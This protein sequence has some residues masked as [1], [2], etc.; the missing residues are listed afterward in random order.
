MAIPS[1]N[2]RYQIYGAI[3]LGILGTIGVIRIPIESYGDVQYVLN[4]DTSTGSV[5]RAYTVS[6]GRFGPYY[7]LSVSYQCQGKNKTFDFTVSRAEYDKYENQT[8]VPVY[9]GNKGRGRGIA[10]VGDPP[11]L[12]DFL[13]GNALQM[14]VVLTMLVIS[15]YLFTLKK[16]RH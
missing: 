14:G 10:T 1:K 5:K 15:R 3:I 12:F 11:S 16:R 13:L 9:C 2:R 7:H 6:T 4:Y 8:Q